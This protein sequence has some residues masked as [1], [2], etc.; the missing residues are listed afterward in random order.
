MASHNYVAKTIDFIS[1]ISVFLK[2]FG[3]P[4]LAYFNSPVLVRKFTHQLNIIFPKNHRLGY[5]EEGENPLYIQEFKKDTI[6]FNI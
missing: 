1:H 5:F 3:M 6:D 2:S 4:A